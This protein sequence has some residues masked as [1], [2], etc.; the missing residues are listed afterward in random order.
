MDEQIKNILSGLSDAGCGQ[1]T[2]DC[3]EKIYKLGRSAELVKYLRRRR[4]DLMDDLH[5]SQKRVD[6]MDYLIRQAER[7]SENN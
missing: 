4:C 6:R 7:I 5:E 2:V 3:A 1:D